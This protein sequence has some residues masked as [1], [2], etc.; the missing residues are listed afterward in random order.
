MITESVDSHSAALAGRLAFLNAGTGAAKVCVYGD[1]HPAL[2]SGAPGSAPLVE[3]ALQDPSGSVAAGALTLLPNGPA[4]ITVSGSATWVRVV[5]GE[6]AT[7]FDMDAGA[8]GSGK[9]CILSDVALW[10]GGSVTLLSA[11]LG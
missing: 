9:E 11:V 1:A 7:A 8:V 3:I 4:Q 5:N 10:A 2:A 6:G